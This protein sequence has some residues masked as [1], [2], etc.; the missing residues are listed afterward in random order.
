MT[1]LKMT[2]GNV[3]CGHDTLSDVLKL[4]TFPDGCQNID[5]NFNIFA[6]FGLKAFFV[7]T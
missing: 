6:S 2:I 4:L 5:F 3:L 7:H 1:C